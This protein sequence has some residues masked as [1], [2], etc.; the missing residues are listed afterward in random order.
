MYRNWSE[1]NIKINQEI[2]SLM[3]TG[4]KRQLIFNSY[5]KLVDTR[6]YIIVKDI[7]INNKIDFI[8]NISAP[9]FKNKLIKHP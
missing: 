8:F 5:Q 7:I 4:N 6:P 3:I 1:G 9:D 2:Y